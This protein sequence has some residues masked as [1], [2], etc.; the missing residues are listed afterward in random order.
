[1]PFWLWAN[2]DGKIE[3]DNIFLNLSEINAAG[4]LLF[5]DSKSFIKAGADLVYGMG[6]NNNNNNKYF[7]PNQLFTGFNLNNW[8]LNIGMYHNKLLLDGLSTCNGNIAMS[9]NARPYPRIGISVS[10]YKPVP[11]LDKFLSFKGEF[12]EGILNDDRYVDRTHLHHKSL[13]LKIYLFQNFSIEAGVEHFVMWG[14]TSQN[15][16][17]GKLPDNCRAYF[18]YI[19]G[20]RGDE[21]FPETDQLNVVGNQ[22]GTYQLL[23][24]QKFVKFGVSINI[25]H[26][27]ED[28]SGVNLS[29]WPDNLIRLSVKMND[30]DN[31]IST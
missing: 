16:E 20:A 14:G 21:Y 7:Q 22:Y 12:D 9:R 31:F 1:M 18:K 3:T 11:L 27:F 29:N 24:T 17:Y 30:Q 26:P 2:T 6:N 25:S 23:L 4:I 15:K 5:S 8:E 19:T 28:H 10:K 13:Y